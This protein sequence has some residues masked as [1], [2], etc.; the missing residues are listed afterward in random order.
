MIQR[1]MEG[2]RGG[3]SRSF[4]KGNKENYGGGVLNLEFFLGV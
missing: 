2:E 4:R 3:A 1:F